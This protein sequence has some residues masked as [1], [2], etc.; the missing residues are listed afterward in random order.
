MTRLEVYHSLESKASGRALAQLHKG[1]VSIPSTENKNKNKKLKRKKKN[2][3]EEKRKRG[4]KRQKKI[5]GG[6]QKMRT[7]HFQSLK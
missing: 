4:K 5:Q 6:P 3:K 7:D 2:D 1:L